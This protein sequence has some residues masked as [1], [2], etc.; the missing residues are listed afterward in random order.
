MPRLA[1][2]LGSARARACQRIVSLTKSAYA[3]SLSIA[4]VSDRL[5]AFALIHH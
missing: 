5:I 3:F 2:R 4:G 1:P